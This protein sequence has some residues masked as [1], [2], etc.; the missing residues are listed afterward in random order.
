MRGARRRRRRDDR[1]RLVQG[2]ALSRRRTAGRQRPAEDQAERDRGPRPRDCGAELLGQS[3]RSRPHGRT[4][5]QGDGADH[6]P[7]RRHRRQEDRHHVRSSR[8][9]VWRQGSQLAR[10]HEELARRDARARP[11]PVGR[12]RLSPL[13]SSGEARRRGGRREIRARELLR[14]AR[15]EP[16]DAVPPAQRSWPQGRAEPRPQSHLFWMG[17]D[18]IASARALG[19]AIHHC[20]GKDTRI[21]R[22][23]ADVDG[24]LELG[25]SPTSPTAPG[26]T[27][28]SAPATTCNGGKSSSPS[29][30]WSA[31]TTGSA[32][33]WK[34][35]RCRPK[36]AFSPRSMH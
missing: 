5:P 12:L 14:D 18:P 26:T 31:T 27:S 30:A 6:P 21:E 15:L 10:L 7:R 1:R 13:A 20:H 32:S 11:L 23:K 35:S 22:G 28:P 34:T 33:R 19:D 24:L 4:S 25:T 36:P 29:C 17:A 2:P 16:A 8:R 3:P 9:R